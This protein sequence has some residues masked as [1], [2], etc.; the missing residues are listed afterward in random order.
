VTLST[1]NG[2]SLSGQA[3]SLGLSS[4]STTGSLSS[5]DWNTFNEKEAAI[6]AGTTGQY[7]RGDKT[8]QT[9]DTSAVAENGNL[10]YTSGRANADFDT[11]LAT[12]STD[13]IGEG[14]TNKYF[15][16]TLARTAVS[17]SGTPLTYNSTTGVF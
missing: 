11:R 12:K 10:Y 5:T 1:A 8:F 6:T 4:T 9:L 7:F 15:S 17:V 16:N 14:I 13:N 3:L 2:L